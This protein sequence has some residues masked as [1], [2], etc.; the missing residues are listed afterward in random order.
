MLQQESDPSALGFQCTDLSEKWIP[1]QLQECCCL[2]CIPYI[3]DQNPILPVYAGKMGILRVKR[4]SPY[5]TKYYDVNKYQ[6][7]ALLCV[8]VFGRY[9]T[10]C[11]P[12][13]QNVGAT[14]SGT[15]TLPYCPGFPYKIMCGTRD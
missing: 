14:N 15:L 9:T 12:N 7:H 3:P 5:L 2:I 4:D 8:G 11:Y 13:A 10:N 6:Y 1:L